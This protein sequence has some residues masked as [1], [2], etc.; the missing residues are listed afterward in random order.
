MERF[1]NKAN[2]QNR[3]NDSTANSGFSRRSLHAMFPVGP[4]TSR[5]A[6]NSVQYSVHNNLVAR[7]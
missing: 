5:L 7:V 1:E 2:N 3:D 6:G 4:P